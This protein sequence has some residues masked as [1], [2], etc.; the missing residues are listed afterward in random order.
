MRTG[1]QGAKRSA[2]TKQIGLMP[3][4]ESRTEGG[5]AALLRKY[6]VGPPRLHPHFPAALALS[7]EAIREAPWACQTRPIRFLR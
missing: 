2:T 1:P 4:P 6:P 3:E 7:L 5:A